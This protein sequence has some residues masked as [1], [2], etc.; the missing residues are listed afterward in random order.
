MNRI[1]I[2][3]PNYIP[4][5]DYFYKMNLVDYFVYFDSIQ[6][7][8]GKSFVS[9]NRILTRQGPIWLTVPIMGKSELNAIKDVKI[10]IGNWQRKHY[11]T[12]EINYGRCKG[13][14]RW[15]PQ[16]KKIYLNSEWKNL[17]DFN[18]ALC[19]LI[20]EAF[21][22]TTKRVRS[23]EICSQPLYG[24]ALILE[25]LKSLKATHYLS[26]KGEG[27]QKHISSQSFD[28]VN[29][30]LSFMDYDHITYSQ[31]CDGF[32]DNLSALDLILTHGSDSIK[33]LFHRL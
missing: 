29:I 10:K 9:R 15:Q 32:I 22:I 11:K 20:C 3:Q 26:G 5:L 6:I 2:H 19:D 18:I 25:I 27:S 31:I 21:E 1:A 16:L 23:S 7:P 12:L 17:C 8:R 24:E 14:E 13:F 33:L 30:N 28:E 4:W